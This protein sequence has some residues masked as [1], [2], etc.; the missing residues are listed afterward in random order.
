MK[1]IDTMTKKLYCTPRSR[2]VQLETESLIAQSIT[3]GTGEDETE[4]MLTRQQ[5]TMSI[6]D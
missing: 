5:E 6:W 1:T 2:Y 3:V 4:E